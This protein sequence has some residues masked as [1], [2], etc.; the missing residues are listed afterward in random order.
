MTDIVNI[1]DIG[2]DFQIT[3]T[4]DDAAVNIST[5][6]DLAVIFKKP[7][8]ST[9]E[10]VASKLTDGVDGV[11]H[12]QTVAGVIDQ[13]GAWTYRGEVTFSASLVFT[14][15]DPASFTVVD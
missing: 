7:D 8:G 4:E 2:T 13:A 15:N 11:L 1:N 9:S 12:Y 10:V 6:T 3:V 14:T 5:A